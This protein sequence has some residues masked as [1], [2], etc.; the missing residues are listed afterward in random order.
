VLWPKANPKERETVL[1]ILWSNPQGTG[2][3]WVRLKDREGLPC[4]PRA[5]AVWT[6]APISETSERGGLSTLR[7]HFV[8][9]IRRR[10]IQNGQKDSSH[11]LQPH[12]S[13][14]NVT[15]C[16]C[17]HPIML[18]IGKSREWSCCCIVD[19]PLHRITLTPRKERRELLQSNRTARLRYFRATVLC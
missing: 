2:T 10:G 18:R 7:S 4:E 3:A 1:Y 6:T 15:D 12:L 9:T 14:A 11:L 19:W 5:N 8:I 16:A 17:K 13:R